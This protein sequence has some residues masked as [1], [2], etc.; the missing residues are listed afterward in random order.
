M[1][2]YKALE[3]LL[4]ESNDDYVS[5]DPLE[6]EQV[7]LNRFKKSK[8]SSFGIETRKLFFSWLK[9]TFLA[10]GSY[11]AASIPTLDVKHKWDHLIE[12]NPPY[13]FYNILY[14][15][16]VRSIRSLAIY[17]NT[18]PTNICLIPNVEYGIQSVLNSIHIGTEDCIIAFDFTY[19][20]VS[21]SIK[22]IC[23]K[24]GGK[25]ITIP[26]R[27]PLSIE[28]LLEDFDDFLRNVKLNSQL[29]IKVMCFEHITSPSAIVLP[30]KELIEICREHQILSLI[31]GAH[32]IGQL[33]LE[34]DLLKPDFYVS[35]LHKWFCTPRGCAFLYIAPQHHHLIH[36][37]VITWGYRQGGHQSEFIWQGTQ[38][39]STY[40]TIP[41]AISFFQ[42]FPNPIK[43]N[44]ELARWCGEMIS[45]CWNTS[46]LVDSTMFASMVS[47]LLPD[48]VR[49]FKGDLHDE[50]QNIHGIE[51]PV[52]TFKG[53]RCV[54]VSIHMYNSKEDCFKACKAVLDLLG[55]EESFIGYQRLHEW[56][57]VSNQV[58]KM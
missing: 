24:F 41:I 12:I 38:D 16:L 22:F 50:L 23:E 33:D 55:Y 2:S 5:P 58:S 18:S 36:P 44:Q 6:F 31:D 7:W 15:Y 8:S 9:G 29:K 25:F 11:G 26:T 3:S 43:R 48:K 28:S 17:L 46:L 30:I 51:L 52:F 54:R 20:A 56:Q 1:V 27:Y 45:S 13:F 47:I 35:N 10:H 49:S 21:Q 34:L 14:R 19:N 57:Y 39:Y 42:W 40:L 53:E 32:G 37:L 4:Q